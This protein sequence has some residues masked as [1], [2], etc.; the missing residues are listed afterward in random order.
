[1]THPLDGVHAKLARADDHFNAI[2]Q[3]I[4]RTVDPSAQLIPGE[5][6]ADGP[7]Y[8]FRSQR[9]SPK[10]TWLSPLIG[11]CVHNLR[12]ALDYL[13]WELVHITGTTGSTKTE[14]PIFT[15]VALYRAH[16][17]QK[18][19]G[20]PPEAE[21]IF[22]RLQ[23]FYGPNSDPFSPDWR[24]PLDEPLAYLYDLERWDKHR[25]L[26]VT[27]DLLAANLVGFEQLGIHTSP[28]R[29]VLHGRFERG[30]VIARAQVRADHPQVDVYLSA[31]FDIAFDRNGPAGGEEVIQTLDDIRQTIS[32]MVLPAFAGYF[33]P[34]EAYVPRW[35]D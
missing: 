35:D 16:A 17:P 11:D 32:R 23:P 2:Q 29:S 13:V 6:D 33:P 5:F 24:D 30:A 9:D 14:F 7:Q 15:N 31:S 21:A 1:M 25:A 26:N 4:Y 22:E 19:R 8:L 18:I 12:A 34:R 27:Q 3:A 10:P 28:A 20:V